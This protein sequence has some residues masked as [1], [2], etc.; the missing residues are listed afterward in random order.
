MLL[1]QSSRLLLLSLK[2]EGK[3]KQM[4]IHKIQTVEQEEVVNTQSNMSCS[5]RTFIAT[6]TARDRREYQRLYY[7]QNRDKAL[8]Y[9][10]E[11]N[12]VHK[13]KVRFPSLTESDRKRLK[14]TSYNVSDIMKASP[15][16]TVRMIEQI[17]KGERAF[18]V[19]W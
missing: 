11:Y 19:A 9:Q 12:R 5:K 17:V 1:V 15:E 13:K 2:S 18:N 10:R 6:K 7:Q 16:K 8:A 14:K 3:E 4:I